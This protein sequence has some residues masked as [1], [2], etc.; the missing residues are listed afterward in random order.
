MDRRKVRKER[1]H[2]QV[3]DEILDAARMVV[4]EKGCPG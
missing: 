3:R 2:E 4:L 1:R